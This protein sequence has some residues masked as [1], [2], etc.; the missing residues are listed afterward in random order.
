MV[1]L[2]G[3]HAADLRFLIRCVPVLCSTI[4]HGSSPT[5][6]RQALDM[7]RCLEGPN[8]AVGFCRFSRHPIGQARQP[9]SI[10]L[11]CLVVFNVAL[12]SRLRFVS[13]LQ[14]WVRCVCRILPALHNS[15]ASSVSCHAV[16]SC[17]RMGTVSKFIKLS[18]WMCW[19]ASYRR[20]QV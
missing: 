13:L 10:F 14:L 16:W 6:W 9:D 5:P 18:V 15:C 12:C 2:N 11:A 4:S 7:C 19:Y 17:R 3:L 20:M 8:D 1:L